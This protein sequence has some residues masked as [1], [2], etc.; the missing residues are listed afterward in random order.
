M[1]TKPTLN[2]LINHAQRKSD[3]SAKELGKLT[4]RQQEAEQKLNLLLEY[5]KNYQSQ[6]QD[7][8]ENGI[9]NIEWL[10]FIAFINKLD[11]AITEQKQNVSIAHSNREAGGKE[12]QLHQAKLKSYDTLSKRHNKL[13]LQ[14]QMKHEQKE[15]DEYAARSNI[16]K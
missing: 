14:Q 11:V 4:S 1:I 15:Q 2:M 7:V 16:Y 8:A 13:E 3:D 12:F 6:L 10:N 5:R 9:N